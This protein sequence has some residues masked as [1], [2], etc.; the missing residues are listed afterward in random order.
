MC[1]YNGRKVTKTE[2]NR[3]K[4]LEKTIY[5]L[6]E[7]LV[8]YR[9]FDY[10]DFPVLRAIPGSH[11]TE[12]VNMEWGFLPTSVKNRE[13]ANKFRFGYKDANGNSHKPYTTL[14]AT[15][16]ELLSNMYQDAA[17]HRRILL[18][19]DFIYEWRHVQVVGKSG[20]LLKTLER[21]PYLIQMRDG[22]P[23]NLAGIYNR[24]TDRDTSTSIDTFAIVTTD[25]NS[26]M[27]QVHNLKHRM[28]TTLPGDL[29]AAWLYN[30]L[31]HQEILDIANYQVASAELIATPLYKDFMKRANPHEPAIYREV[32]ELIYAA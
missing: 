24:W 19:P 10:N 14:N 15:S 23:F 16:E 25:A 27:R 5:F 20:K 8:I 12:G 11:E 26:L 29:A 4:D 22:S 21:F 31:T 6:N 2:Y 17:L 30:D 18:Q 28:A 7:E 13:A 3:L 1:Y 32:P 9:G